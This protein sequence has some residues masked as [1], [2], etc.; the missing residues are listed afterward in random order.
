MSPSFESRPS[1]RLC[2]VLCRTETTALTTESIVELMPAMVATIWWN[3]VRGR[4][5]QDIGVS[6]NFKDRMR[7][8]PGQNPCLYVCFGGLIKQV[9]SIARG[10]V[11]NSAGRRPQEW[12]I[13]QPEHENGEKHRSINLRED[14]A[15]GSNEVNIVMDSRLFIRPPARKTRMY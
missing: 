9:S 2:L 1:L 6:A 12:K 5:K 7:I 14:A 13:E 15:V 11:H 4:V 10:I 8:T 3:T